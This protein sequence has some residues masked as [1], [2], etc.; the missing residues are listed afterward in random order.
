M[1]VCLGWE[2]MDEPLAFFCCFLCYVFS[3]SALAIEAAETPLLLPDHR[4]T[5]EE[6]VTPL[7]EADLVLEPDTVG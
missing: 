6:E 2:L 3:A 4:H 7:F 1:A 5:C